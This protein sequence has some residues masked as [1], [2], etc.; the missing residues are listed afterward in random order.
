[1]RTIFLLSI[2]CAMSASSAKADWQYTKWGMSV[3]QVA[4][5]SKGKAQ[6]YSSKYSNETYQVE[7]AAPF[8]SGPF[9]FNAHFEFQGSKGLAIVALHPVDGTDCPS[10]E[11]PL[12]SKYGESD[13]E[14]RRFGAYKWDDRKSNNVVRFVPNGNDCVLIY[15][16]LAARG[17][18]S[19]L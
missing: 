8:Q 11:R 19:G 4:K 9:A 17:G 13:P 2:T 15:R 6:P 12:I 7:L 5:A 10:I 14:P 1:M 3:A 18:A 16:E